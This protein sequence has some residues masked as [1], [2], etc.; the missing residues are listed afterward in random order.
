M[1]SSNRFWLMLKYTLP[2]TEKAKSR[3]Y[4]NNGNCKI[5]F[6]ELQDLGLS[7]VSMDENGY[8]MAYV[9]SNIEENEPTVG[10]LHYV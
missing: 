2:V 7:E 6:Q 1:R 9:P 4:L 5:Y 8:I 3:L 10:S